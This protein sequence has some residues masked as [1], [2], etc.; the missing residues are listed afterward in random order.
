MDPVREHSKKARTTEAMDPSG[1]VAGSNGLWSLCQAG[2]HTLRCATGRRE[3]EAA[4]GVPRLA[5]CGTLDDLFVTYAAFSLTRYYG[6]IRALQL[7]RGTTI[8]LGQNE[9]EHR[10]DPGSSIPVPDNGMPTC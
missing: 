10:L 9:P 2:T 4:N 3:Q 7:L 5:L 1:L 6:T 8:P